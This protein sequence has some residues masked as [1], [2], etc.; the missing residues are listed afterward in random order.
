MDQKN[1]AMEKRPPGRPASGRQTVSFTMVLDVGVMTNI[2]QI[3]NSERISK[4][5]V[6]R[7]A[8]EYALSEWTLSAMRAE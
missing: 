5:E 1:I 3:A 6:I 4:G 2:K 7:R 8:L